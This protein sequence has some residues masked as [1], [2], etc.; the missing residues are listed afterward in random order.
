MISFIGMSEYTLSEVASLLNGEGIE[1]SYGKGC[2]SF[3]VYGMYFVVEDGLGH[4]INAQ[5]YSISPTS[6]EDE[7]DLSVLSLVEE[8]LQWLKISSN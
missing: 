1:V 3:E 8:M 5:V 6:L 7:D 4:F 2:I